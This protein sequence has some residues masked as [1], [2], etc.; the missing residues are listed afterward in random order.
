MWGRRR[1]GRRWRRRWRWGCSTSA[2][3][4]IGTTAVDDTVVRR[5][6]ATT[7]FL[8]KQIVREAPLELKLKGIPKQQL[9]P[10]E[11][12]VSFV[13]QSPPRGQH[14]PLSHSP[15]PEG[16]VSC[17]FP[18]SPSIRVGSR[19]CPTDSP[20][21]RRGLLGICGVN[22]VRGTIILLT[23][24]RSLPPAVTSPRTPGKRESAY[25]A[26]IATI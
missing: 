18:R 17:L 19:L 5:P 6:A 11:Q 23:R 26:K 2:D 24:E 8:K 12:H 9:E 20:G 15:Y 4:S 10:A 3:L 1:R 16:H 25:N 21:W 14:P 22:N 13:Q 7:T